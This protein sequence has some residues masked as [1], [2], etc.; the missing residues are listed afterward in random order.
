MKIHYCQEARRTLHR[1]GVPAFRTPQEAVRTFMNIY[2]RTQN[3][4]LL[5]QTPNE[6]PIDQTSPKHLKGILRRSFAEGRE[7]LNLLDSF[8]FLEAYKIP[9]V[10]TLVA[11]TVEESTVIASQLG[12]PVMMK[13]LNSQNSVKSQYQSVTFDVFSPDQ[14]RFHF[15]QLLNENKDFIRANDFQGVVIQ[16]KMLNSPCQLFLGSRKDPKFGSIICLGT[17][18]N[19][20]EKDR[21]LSVGFPPLN[22]VLARQI[23]EN[24]KALQYCKD[25]CAEKFETG[26]IEEMIIRF[27]QI[28]VDFPEIKKIDINPIIVKDGKAPRLTLK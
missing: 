5:F 28:T 27:S 20:I 6:I 22:Q 2:T 23:M 25:A 7:T 12:Y 16:P 26:P 11:K 19:L 3:L 4:E 21:E 14:L 1:N 10:K 15:N 13:E 9:V 17:G 24:T 8:Q 18:G